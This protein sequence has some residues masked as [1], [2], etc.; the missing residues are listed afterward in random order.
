[1]IERRLSNNATLRKHASAIAGVAALMFAPLQA[2]AGP[3]DTPRSV[4]EHAFPNSAADCQCPGVYSVINMG[5]E[6]G[7]MALLNERG[8]AAFASYGFDG[9]RNG[10]FD[11]ERVHNIGSLGGRYTRVQGL[12]KRGVVVGESE[13]GEQR[14]NLL[15]FSWTVADGMRALPGT[16]VSSANAINDRGYIAGYTSAPGISAR[17]IRWN[18]HG[19]ITALGPVPH[20]L[21]QAFAINQKG[22]TTDFSDLASGKIHATVWDRAGILTDLGTLGGDFAFGMHINDSNAVAGE[23]LD[24]ANERLIGFFWSRD[25]G[26]VPINVEGGGA[27]TVVGMNNRGEVV[28]DTLVGEQSV[29]YQWSLK[30]GMVPLPSG[31]ATRSDVFDINNNSEMVGLVARHEADGGGLRAVRWPGMT[32]P[33]D[34]NTRLHRAPAG[35]MLQAGAAIN[36]DGT[37]LA[38]S[39]AGLVMLRP[40]KHGTDAP[41]LGPMLGLPE[42]IEI[43]QDL[44]MT[45]GFADNSHA[46]T[47][48]ASVNW[49]DGCASQVPTVRQAHGIG[50]VRLQHTF[51]AAGYYTVAARVTDSGGRST[52]LQQDI[53]VHA[54]GLASVSGKGTLRHKATMAQRHHANAPLRFAL[55]APLGKRPAL[56]RTG[57]PA[58]VFAGPFHFRSAQVTRT[59]VAGRQIRLDGTGR[60]NGRPGYRFALDAID[61][62]GKPGAA[63]ERLRVRITHVDATSER[64]GQRG[65]VAIQKWKY[66]LK[67][68]ATRLAGCLS[69]RVY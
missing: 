26:M 66:D 19:N 35:L 59:D 53:M 63:P 29:A 64:R 16:S 10:F 58:V 23:S 49:N 2:G 7:M 22:I 27:R 46:E 30:R 62:D 14:S 5:Q 28:G 34:L 31:S 12:N 55:W 54:P 21:S 44:T 52:E 11:G 1:M 4:D 17:A 48:R 57:A 13:D 50:Q 65:I 68:M 61:S 40:G 25:S 18:P 24:A 38:H 15:A 51:C 69:I 56:M 42:V 33:I 20:S 60:L 41:V 9:I 67:S 8:Q 3:G 39:N 43:G 47:H 6:A 37:I 45:I 32:A 36:D